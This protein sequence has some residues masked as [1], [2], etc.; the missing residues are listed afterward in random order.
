SG[1]IWKPKSGKENANP[2]VS[3]PLG[4]AS[5]TANIMDTM[6]SRSSIMSNTPLSS[7]AFAAHRDC[8]IH[9][10]LWVLKAHDKKSQPSN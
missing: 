7:N 6:I 8:H 10:R 5:R 9:R 4:K 3:M 1:Y 2:N